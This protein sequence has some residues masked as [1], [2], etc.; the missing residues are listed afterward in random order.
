MVKTDPSQVFYRSHREGNEWQ[1]ARVAD[2]DIDWNLYF[3]VGESDLGQSHL[4]RYRGLGVDRHSIAA[5]P[6]FV[7]LANGDLRLKPESP[8]FELGFRAIDAAKIGLREDLPR[9]PPAS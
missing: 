9:Y 1:E 7:D 6:L 8:A 5:D 4:Q 2:C 3:A